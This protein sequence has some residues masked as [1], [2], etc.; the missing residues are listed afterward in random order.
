MSFNPYLEL[1]LPV[2]SR[3]DCT[4][5]SHPLELLGVLNNCV[6]L[7]QHALLGHC[8]CQSV[9]AQSPGED[10]TNRACGVVLCIR[11]VVAAVTWHLLF[12]GLRHGLQ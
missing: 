2:S 3:P 4:P 12:C 8:H 1:L 7:C 11:P 5:S 6:S 10:V 9:V